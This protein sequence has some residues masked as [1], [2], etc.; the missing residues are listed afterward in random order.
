[1]R[2][3]MG[4]TRA[5]LAAL[6]AVAYALPVRAPSG[7]KVVYP[8]PGTNDLRAGGGGPCTY[9]YLNHRGTP[10]VSAAHCVVSFADMDKGSETTPTTRQYARDLGG[11]EGT[12]DDAGHILAHQL[13]G[14][15][16]WLHAASAGRCCV[17]GAQRSGAGCSAVQQVWS[18]FWS[19]GASQ[20]CCVVA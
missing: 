16:S 1:M 4:A 5:L 7:W 3:K 19:A 17:G 12:Q 8:T 11:P 2:T 15:G 18:A 14:C 9:T 20:V 10:V 6:G 13:G